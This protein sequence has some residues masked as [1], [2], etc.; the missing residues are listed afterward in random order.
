MFGPK[1]GGEK[2]DASRYPAL[3]RTPADMEEMEQKVGP[4]KKVDKDEDGDDEP[5]EEMRW[6]SRSSV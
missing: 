1:K 6:V 4:D 5:E 3:L 2:A